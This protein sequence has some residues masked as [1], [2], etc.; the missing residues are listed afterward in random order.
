MYR[1]AGGGVRQNWQE[2]WG[3]DPEFKLVSITGTLPAFDRSGERFVATRGGDGTDAL[4]VVDAATHES[5]IVFQDKDR[6]AVAPQ[7]SPRGD[8]IIFGL[9]AFKT[10][11]MQGDFSNSRVDGGAQVAR[12]YDYVAPSV[13]RWGEDG[14]SSCSACPC[15]RAAPNHPAG[16][17]CRISQLRHLHAAFACRQ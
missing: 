6:S 10:V 16:V 12:L 15:H 3:R 2:L 17:N 1:K 14:F 9:G 5:R 4:E 11:H 7:W 13:S 8:S